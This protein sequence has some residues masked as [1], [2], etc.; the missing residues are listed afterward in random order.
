MIVMFFPGC[1]FS[2][3]DSSA[4]LP[5]I[6]VEFC[7]STVSRVVE[8]TNLGA[9]LRDDLGVA[10]GPAV[11]YALTFTQARQLV[12]PTI[13][14]LTAIAEG[15]PDATVGPGDASIQRHRHIYGKFRHNISFR[16]YRLTAVTNA[17]FG[18]REG[19]FGSTP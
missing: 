12:R 9:L 13:E 4:T 7:H 15:I 17:A 1:R 14:P 10:V 19:V 18:E 3:V 8:T 5:R 6:G 2:L 11:G 16:I